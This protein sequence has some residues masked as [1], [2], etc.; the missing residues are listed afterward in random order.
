[1]PKIKIDGVEGDF[2]NGTTL[3]QACEQL[4]KEVPRF[5]YHERLS[6][7]GMTINGVAV[8]D[9]FEAY[10]TAKSAGGN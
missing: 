9:L 6:V 4:G 3:L 8:R 2:E 5:C 10:E 7:A 1:M